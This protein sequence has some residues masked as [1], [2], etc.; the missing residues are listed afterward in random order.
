MSEHSEYKAWLRETEQKLSENFDKTMLAIAGGALGLSI[1]FIKDIIGKGEM[2]H[3]WLLVLSWAALTACII[4]MLWAFHMGLKAYRKAQDQVD[5]GSIENETPGGFFS[6]ILNGLN[7]ISI[8]LLSVGLICLFTFSYINLAKEKTDGSATN[9]A[10]TKTTATTSKTNSSP[11]S[12][13]GTSCKGFTSTSSK[14]IV[15]DKP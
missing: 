4:L 9:K 6:A 7:Y 15:K 10:N 2:L 5:S 13:Y 1:T 12:K 11:N 3:G 14:T 8:S